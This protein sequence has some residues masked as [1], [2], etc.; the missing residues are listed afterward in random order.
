VEDHQVKVYLGG[1]PG[2]GK[3]T[4]A[5]WMA[6]QGWFL[7]GGFDSQIHTPRIVELLGAPEDHPAFQHSKVLGEGG[8]LERAPEFQSMFNRVG[9]Y[10]V[11][12][13]G[14]REKL[15]E[16]RRN[17]KD[18]PILVNMDWIS[19]VDAQKCKVHWDQEINMWHEG[20]ERK[21]GPEVLAEIMEGI[22]R[23]EQEA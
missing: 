15:Y 6:E 17:R 19:M 18:D 20:G 9:F 12:L 8:F 13:T 16:S 2:A 23:G 7:L 10:T 4:L 5:Q 3:T 14:P 22:T 1:Y 11:W 21:T